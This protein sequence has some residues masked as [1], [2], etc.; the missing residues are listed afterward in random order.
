MPGTQGLDGF[1]PLEAADAMLDVDDVVAG[2]ECRRL[3]E[4]VA[5]LL[6]FPPRPDQPVA[7]NVLLGDQREV[8]GLDAVFE[9]DDGETHRVFRLLQRFFECLHLG[10]VLDAVVAHQ[11]TQPLARAVGPGGDDHPLAGSPAGGGHSRRQRRTRWRR[12]SPVPARSHG[13]GGRHRER[14]APSSPLPVRRT[15]STG[16]RAA[17]RPPSPTPARSI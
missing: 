2:R 10:D 14:I 16:E 11:R 13:R 4:D 8:V 7:E 5:R 12:R 6:R 15:G 17:G 3:G 9:A 1:Q